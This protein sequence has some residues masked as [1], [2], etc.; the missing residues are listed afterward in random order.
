[1]PKKLFHSWG[2]WVYDREHCIKVRTCTKEGCNYCR[3]EEEKHDFGEEDGWNY[4]QSD[5]CEQFR[6]CRVCL[7]YETRQAEHQF[8]GW[9]YHTKNCC[10]RKRVCSH[11]GYT[12]FEI[13]HEIREAIPRE[14]ECVEELRCT[15]CGDIIIRQKE[16]AWSTRELLYTDCLEHAIDHIESKKESL[17]KLAAIKQESSPAG[18]EDYKNA[19]LV[20]ELGVLTKRQELLK[21]KK[22][23]ADPDDVGKY[24]MNCKTVLY[25]GK[26]DNRHSRLKGFLSYSWDNS[27]VADR[28]DQGLR[29]K[30]I[31]I[32]RDIHDLDIGTKLEA[33]MNRI[34]HSQF[35]IIILS[36][37]YLR[38]KN[39]MYEAVKALLVLVRKRCLLMTV[40]VGLD[41][42][43][44][45]LWDEYERYWADKL[46]GAK[47]NQEPLH[48]IVM[49]QSIL[50]SL[51]EFLSIVIEHK[52]EKVEC[53]AD[54]DD[55]LITQIKEKIR[56]IPG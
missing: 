49:Y 41:V 26:K 38:S 45:T 37:S 39:C 4:I 25:L 52:Y 9:E 14:G 22:R 16:H 33:F 34:E 2:E 54:I 36:D 13:R 5:S 50:D 24:C 8:N 53:A 3:A 18:Y 17:F 19:A 55:V 42:A 56:N 11:C 20:A 30:G 1:M 32:T 23:L 28:V 43:N 21:D 47:G 48:D 29:T 10:E 7:K 40:S 46:K 27:G 15:R 31:Y 6:K 44:K 51:R 12:E 35:V